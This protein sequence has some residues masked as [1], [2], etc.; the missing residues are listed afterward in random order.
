MKFLGGRFV[1]TSF[2]RWHK[3]WR[4]KWDNLNVARGSFYHHWL[5]GLDH[6]AGD[7]RE[8]GLRFG[9][10]KSG[11]RYSLLADHEMVKWLWAGI[12]AGAS[13]LRGGSIRVEDLRFGLDPVEIDT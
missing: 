9:D 1:P 12:W 3:F 10:S 13:A 6:A 7:S 8:T 5:L 2:C 4:V 11:H